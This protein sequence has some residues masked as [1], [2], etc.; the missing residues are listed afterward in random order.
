MACY[1]WMYDM[2]SDICTIYQEF[3]SLKYNWIRCIGGSLFMLF[4]SEWE[5]SLIKTQL[6]T[7]WVVNTTLTEMKQLKY[8]GVHTYHYSTYWAKTTT[9]TK[10]VHLIYIKISPKAYRKHHLHNEYTRLM[11]GQS[12]MKSIFWHRH[13]IE[14]YKEA[15]KDLLMVFIDLE[16]LYERVPKEGKT[17]WS[18]DTKERVSNILD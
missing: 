14:K 9:Q 18:R 11:I 16:K 10:Q 3:H 17:R 6:Q 1:H 15:W 5:I 2:T 7:Y 4:L 12:T 13:L 8:T